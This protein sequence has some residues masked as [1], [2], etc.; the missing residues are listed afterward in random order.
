MSLKHVHHM[1]NLQTITHSVSYNYKSIHCKLHSQIHQ[2]VGSLLF[3]WCT[4]MRLI[5]VSAITLHGFMHIN[6]KRSV[7]HV[8][9]DWQT[10][11]EQLKTHSFFTFSEWQ[12][13]AASQNQI[14]FIFSLIVYFNF[15]VTILAFH[16]PRAISWGC[17]SFERTEWRKGKTT[18][19]I[20]EDI[21]CV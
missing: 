9:N 7:F 12:F 14:H 8:S 10:L 21:N 1:V 16:T 19:E 2:N 17:L 18:K 6:Q 5:K 20:E 13:S 11:Q 4:L 15:S 3:L